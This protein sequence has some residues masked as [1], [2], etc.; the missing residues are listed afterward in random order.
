MA[1]SV[2]ISLDGVKDLWDSVVDYF[3]DITLYQQ[4]AWGAVGLGLVLIIVAI[5]VW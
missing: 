4:L 2:D 3:N 5:I 1:K